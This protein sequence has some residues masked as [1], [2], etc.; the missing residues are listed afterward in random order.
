[1]QKDSVLENK[2]WFDYMKFHCFHGN[3]LCDIKEWVYVQ[4]E[5]RISA[6]THPRVLNLVH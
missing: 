4:K 1:M 2:F 3:P 5:T 6:A